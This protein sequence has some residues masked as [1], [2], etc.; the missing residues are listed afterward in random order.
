MVNS[1]ADLGDTKTVELRVAM[2]EDGDEGRSS[3]AGQQFLRRGQ[4]GLNGN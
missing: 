2:G 4:T 3:R 1:W